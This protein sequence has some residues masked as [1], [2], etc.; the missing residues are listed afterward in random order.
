MRTTPEQVSLLQSSTSHQ[1]KMFHMSL[2][3][4]NT[5]IYSGNYVEMG[6]E[7][8]IGQSQCRDHIT[9][10]LHATSNAH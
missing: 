5:L 4:T 10:P 3:L 9:R 1:Q 6:F 8:R 7:P 2:N